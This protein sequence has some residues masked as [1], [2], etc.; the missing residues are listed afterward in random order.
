MV[1]DIQKQSSDKLYSFPHKGN[2]EFV[3]HAKWYND[4]IIFVKNNKIVEVKFK[5]GS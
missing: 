2:Y 4:Q 1:Y 3:S 5:K